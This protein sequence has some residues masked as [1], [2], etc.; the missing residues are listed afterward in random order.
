MIRSRMPTR[1][2]MKP[3]DL[4]KAII[5][6]LTHSSVLF[7]LI[8]F[9]LLIWFSIWGGMLGL[10][11]LF[12]VLPAVFR[13]QMIILEARA[14]GQEPAPPDNELFNWWG[15]AWSLFPVPLALLAG[16]A[17]FTAGENFGNAGAAVVLL[18]SGGLLPVSFAILA[19]THSPLQS[20]NPIAIGRL[21]RKCGR[22]FW[23]APT[24]LIVAG[25]LSLQ[26]A[27][28]PLT[29][30]IL[31]LLL[32]LY[33]VFSLIGSLIEPYGLIDDVSIPDAL[34]RS[35]DEIAGDVEKARTD[36]LTHAY[37][38]I[39]RGNRD[40]GFAH[41]MQSIGKDPD[42]VA[43]WAW[44]FDR[45]L[46]WETTEHA[47]FFAQHYIHDLLQHGEKIPAL[48]VILRCRLLNE[49]FRPLTADLPAAIEAANFCG[50]IEL[51]TVLKR[52]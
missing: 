36:I 25:W 12:L 2:K 5:Y 24:Y 51:A 21:L 1:K 44:F 19:I 49:S 28:L 13:F 37:G 8:V 3:G 30:I 11:L 9:W 39:S 14:K 18:L 48:K 50:N 33:S 34:E 20:V 38:F 22:T 31:I 16:W 40:G 15:N 45:M 10:F 26:A 23:I 43:A 4:L 6:P 32:L 41:V 35:E 46:R 47:L 7:S 52:F 17:T 27:A 42:P 29:A